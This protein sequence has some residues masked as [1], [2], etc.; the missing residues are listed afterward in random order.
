MRG[1]ALFIVTEGKQENCIVPDFSQAV[2][3]RP[4]GKGR[5]EAG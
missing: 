5:L 3:A 4:S 1:T 2:P